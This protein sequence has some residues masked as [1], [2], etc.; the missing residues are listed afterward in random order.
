MRADKAEVHGSAAH[1]GEGGRKLPGS[2]GGA[3]AGRAAAERTKP[4]ALRGMEAVVE[5]SN[6]VRA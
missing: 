6:M 3:E 4:E 5:R 1:D 2:D